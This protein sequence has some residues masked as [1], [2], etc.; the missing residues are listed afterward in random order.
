MCYCRV[1]RKEI[2]GIFQIDF[3]LKFVTVTLHEDR[4]AFLHVA[5]EWILE[6]LLDGKVL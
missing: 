2:F 3:V 1:F 4:R 6:Y 5:G